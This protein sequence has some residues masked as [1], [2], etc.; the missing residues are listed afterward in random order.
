[1]SDGVSILD[2]LLSTADECWYRRGSTNVPVR[3][4]GSF[5][6]SHAVRFPM[7]RIDIRLESCRSRPT[8]GIRYRLVD[9]TH[10]IDKALQLRPMEYSKSAFVPQR[11]AKA[12]DWSNETA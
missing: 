5:S 11:G 7:V 2:E 4:G 12:T 3:L 6:F 1:M 10:G 9:S 8:I